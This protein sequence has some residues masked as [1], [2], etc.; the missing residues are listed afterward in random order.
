MMVHGSTA[1][2]FNLVVSYVKASAAD[3]TGLAPVKC[4]PPG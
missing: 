3:A 1:A 4:G 2:T